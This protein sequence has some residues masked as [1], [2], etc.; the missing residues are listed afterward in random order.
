MRRHSESGRPDG[1]QL[2]LLPHR[3][4]A[5]LPD[6]PGIHRHVSDGQTQTLKPLP[7]PTAV[8]EAALSIEGSTYGSA[9][10]PS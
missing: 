10:F 3:M 5:F 1:P 8:P 2:L 4:Q 9:Y 7:N 6:H